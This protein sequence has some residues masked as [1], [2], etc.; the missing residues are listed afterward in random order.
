[1]FLQ[2]PKEGKPAIREMQGVVQPFFGDITLDD[3][4]KQYGCG[5]HGKESTDR[6]CEEKQRQD[7]FQLLICLPSNDR[8]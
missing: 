2:T 7:V 8:R 5:V 1:M 3:A 6:P 4:G